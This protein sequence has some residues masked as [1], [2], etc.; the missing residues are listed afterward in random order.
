MLYEIG[1]STDASA[2]ELIDVTV[3]TAEAESG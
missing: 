3:V 2:G 1:L